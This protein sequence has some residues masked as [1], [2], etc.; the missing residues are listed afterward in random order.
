MRVNYF[1]LFFFTL[2]VS[3]QIELKIDSISSLDSIPF[4]RKFTI[5]Y[6]T[7]N[8]TD[9]EVS[10]ILYPK[11]LTDFNS[12]FI[13]RTIFTKYTKIKNHLILKIFS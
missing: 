13:A 3:A 8:L 10:F 6:H 7:K 5:N 1:L 4:E 11:T 2:S 12:G 9:K